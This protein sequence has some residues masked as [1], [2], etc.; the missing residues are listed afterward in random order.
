MWTGIAGFLGG[1]GLFFVGLK[2]TG[3]GV[4]AIVG[5]RM[6]KLFL[7]CTRRTSAAGLLGVAAGFVFQS[8]SSVTVLLASL[9]DAGATTL[10]RALPVLFGAHVGL[11]CLVLLAVVDIKALVLVLLGVSGLMLA[12]ERPAKLQPAASIAFG[13][14]MLLLG[15]QTVR[16]GTAPLSEAIWFQA[17]F[18]GNG[19][20]L[21]AIFGV[22]VLACLVLQSVTGVVILAIT[23]A[24]THVITANAALAIF[25]G[26]L[27][28]SV[29]L[30]YGYCIGYSGVRKQLALAQM[31]FS[32]VGL[33]VFLPLFALETIFGLPLLLGQ[34]ARVFPTLAEQLTAIGI[35]YNLVACVLLV[36]FKEPCARLLV[37]L[38]PE[39]ADS[40]SSLA[41]A[42][43]LAE[44][45]PDTG[46]MLINQEQGRIMRHLPA[47]TA[48]LRQEET[49]GRAIQSA[50]A[51]HK[52]VDALSHRIEDCLLEM[53]SL[54]HA[55]GNATTIA[56]L[57]SNQAAIRAVNDT[58]K[59]MIDELSQAVGSPS[60]Q[61]LRTLFLES[62]DLLLLQA[63]DVFGDTDELSWELFLHLVSD[64]GPT[65]ERLRSRYL[66]ER[67]PLSL[68]D[69][70]R[71]MHVT[72]LYDRCAW[73]LRR[74]AE[75]QRRV[76]TDSG[77]E[78]AVPGCGLETEASLSAG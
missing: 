57:Q 8:L 54:G 6:R 44:V 48:A 50:R 41:Y 1:M 4:K 61:H 64:K 38:S 13:V 77:R 34:A 25:F 73:L 7:Q 43:E 31:L 9:I 30:R 59:Q 60:L 67:T 22:G 74:L 75:Q 76:L 52:A 12:F 15:L 46:L 39:K 53:V 69:Q 10:P 28:G 47:Y 71:L 56:L 36:G 16:M 40:L 51:L 14:A 20:P 37:R 2:L 24:S 78:A 5:R 62:L 32:F 18:S 19:L 21:P 63:G 11:S 35:A 66:H 70:W 33:G 26:S 49:P 68:D 58:L 55:G 23:L 72:G 29:V 65:M 3:D 42:R 45:A 17:L 27:F